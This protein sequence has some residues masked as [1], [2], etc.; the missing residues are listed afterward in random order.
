MRLFVSINLPEEF[1]PFFRSLQSELNG[2]E[3]GLM[4]A[5]GFHLT[6]F[7]LGEVEEYLVKDISKELGKINFDKFNLSFLNK[8]GVFQSFGQIKSVYVDL[9][10]SIELLDLQKKVAEVVKRFGFADSRKFSP[11]ITV[12]RVKSSGE[13]LLR[14]IKDVDVRKREFEV[15]AFYLMQSR[16]ASGGSEYEI[17]EKFNSF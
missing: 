11:H 7:F 15:D 8:L 10:E 2:F 5:G 1:N 13:D 17:L 3:G 14:K 9:K 12:S 6:L 16:L 4:H